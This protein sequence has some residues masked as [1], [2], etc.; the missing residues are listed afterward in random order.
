VEQAP[1]RGDALVFH[2]VFRRRLGLGKNG[3]DVMTRLLVGREEGSIVREQEAALAR[4]QVSHQAEHDLRVVGEFQ[5][6]L[7]EPLELAIKFLV[8][9]GRAVETEAQHANDE[10]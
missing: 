6:V 2:S 7:D 10:E 4:L 3:L 8:R 1:V 5:I 9:A